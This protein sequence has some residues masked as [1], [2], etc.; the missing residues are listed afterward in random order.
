R[1]L[2]Y[3]PYTKSP[4]GTP[5]ALRTTEYA[6]NRNGLTATLDYEIASHQLRASV[7]HENNGFDQARRFYATSPTNIPSPYD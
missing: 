4:D 2:W 6:I 3:T 1:G 7:W 5:I